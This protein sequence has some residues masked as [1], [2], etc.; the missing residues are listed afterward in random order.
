[1]D[2]VE[3]QRFIEDLCADDPD[4]MVEVEEVLGAIRESDGVGGFLVDH[5]K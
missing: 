3:R 1:M 2:R 5:V 4:L